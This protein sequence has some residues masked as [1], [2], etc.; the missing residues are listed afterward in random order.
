MFK[1]IKIPFFTAPAQV[2]HKVTVVMLAAITLAMGCETAM[3]MWLQER[4]ALK[5]RE[6]SL[7]VLTHSIAEGI[8]AIMMTGSTDASVSFVSHFKEVPFIQG[9]RIVRYDG[10][11]A[12]TDNRTIDQVNMALEEARY[13]RR[14]QEAGVQLLAEDDPRLVRA[15]DKNEVVSFYEQAADGSRLLTF[16][17]PIKTTRDC[18]DCHA[19]SRTRGVVQLS[20]SLKAID[21]A[22]A[23]SQRNALLVLAVTL[24]VTALVASQLLRRTVTGPLDKLMQGMSRIAEGDLE[25]EVVVDR[26]DEFGRLAELFNV[27][28]GEVRQTHAG[29]QREQDKLTT[30]ILGADEGIVI[31]DAVGTVVL[32][33]PS[34]E[35]FLGKS[36]RDIMRQGFLALFDD[37]AEMQGWLSAEKTTDTIIKVYNHRLFRVYASVIRDADGQVIG[38]AALL[39]DV[40]EEKRLEDELRRLSTTD[41]LT[42]LFN[43]RHLDSVLD[44]E[45]SRASRTGAPLAVM[46]FDI[47]HFKKFNDTH[48]H[49]QGDRV[50]KAVSRWFAETLRKHDM[51]FRYGGEEFIAIL[52]ET[53]LD[54]AAALAE[55]LR[56]EIE[57]GE[58]DGLRVTISIGVAA[59]PE[60]PAA[61]GEALVD[62]ADQALYVSKEGGRNRVSRAVAPA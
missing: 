33:N 23:E 11:E 16:L 49:D 18:R 40:T 15:L 9:F 51:A 31:T 57:A 46:M 48:G 6:Q 26:K 45:F 39:R 52:P 43:R 28:A 54:G 60:I 36:A 13:P 42:S 12:F 58:V 21:D 61:T 34:A 59:Y 53:P 14:V 55:R 44:V 5:E 22:L 56:K 29:L 27:M 7:N 30:I 1:K 62:A 50:L 4:A 17:A 35:A 41:G 37:P 47:D 19:S 3:Q 10:K 8:E 20:T 32:V 25:H 38:S 24:V 2:R